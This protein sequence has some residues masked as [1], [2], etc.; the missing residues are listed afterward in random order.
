MQTFLHSKDGGRDGAFLGTLAG[1]EGT[2]VKSTLQ[3]KFIS[4]P[5]A[6]LTLPGLME[7]LPKAK[8][9]AAKGLAYD[10][11]IITNAGVSGT[12][13]TEICAA[14]Q[15]VGVKTC[16][17]FG[18]DWL[19]QQL[20]QNPKLRMFVPRVYGIGDLSHIITGHGYKQAKAMARR[21]SSNSRAPEGSERDVRV[22]SA[23]LGS[24]S[25]CR[26]ARLGSLRRRSQDCEGPG[27][28]V[29]DKRRQ[30]TFK[31]PIVI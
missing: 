16:R 28:E 13:D 19:V 20:T 17:I 2:S 4:K 29:G 9:L 15:T 23:T 24:S 12:T 1:D 7:E 25:Q 14:F 10:Y 11:V 18:H 3:C 21:N 6:N 26:H 27:F 22:S 30:L 31:A 8:A 5:G